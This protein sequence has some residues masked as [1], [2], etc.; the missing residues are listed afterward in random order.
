[1]TSSKKKPKVNEKEG[2]RRGGRIAGGKKKRGRVGDQS[3]VRK[4]KL[5]IKLSAKALWDG[6]QN[7]M[8]RLFRK[9]GKGRKFLALSPEGRT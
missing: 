6:S 1:M 7:Q 2:K 4:I 9:K 3:N 8:K 5:R